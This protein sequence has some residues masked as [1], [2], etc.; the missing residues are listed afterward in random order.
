MKIT[1]VGTGYVG[2]VSGTCFAETG[3]NVIS[4]DIDKEKVRNLNHGIIPIYEPGLEEIMKRN[5]K[6]ERLYFSDDISLSIQK[7]QVI[8]IA[9]GSPQTSDGVANMEYVNSVVRAI[10]QNLEDL[11]KGNFL[12]EILEILLKKKTNNLNNGF[13]SSIFEESI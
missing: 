1:I 4:V 11:P 2:L 6:S 7:S 3:N 10:N 12:G 9:V 13:N 8:I 5:V